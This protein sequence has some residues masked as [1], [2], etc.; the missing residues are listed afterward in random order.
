MADKV[1]RNWGTNQADFLAALEGQTV[2]IAFLDGKALNGTLTGV[3]TYELFVKPSRGPEVMVA[4]GAIKYLHQVKPE[5][6]EA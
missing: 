2:K 1:N 4:K 3:D 5:N 6:G